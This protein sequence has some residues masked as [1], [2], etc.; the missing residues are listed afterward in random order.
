MERAAVCGSENLRNIFT[1]QH[2][3]CHWKPY[4]SQA[5]Q[6]KDIDLLIVEEKPKRGDLDGFTDGYRFI[7][8][9]RVDAGCELPIILV[10]STLQGGTSPQKDLI[11]QD[12]FV[13]TMA[14]E[15]LIKHSSPKDFKKYFPPRIPKEESDK[16]FTDLRLTLYQNEGYI[17]ELRHQIL[18]LLEKLERWDGPDGWEKVDQLLSK[19]K[20]VLQEWHL[21][22]HLPELDIS[23]AGHFRDL[24][25]KA[26]RPIIKDW[27]DQLHALV[28]RKP[29]TA[30]IPGQ[31]S[32][33]VLYIS[34]EH[35]HQ[36]MLKEQLGTLST[37]LLLE[38]IFAEDLKSAQQEAR[39]LPGNH[40]VT[41][42]A[43]FRFRDK[44]TGKRGRRNGIMIIDQLRRD[45]PDWQYLLLSNFPV[46]SYKPLMP[47]YPLQIFSK[48]DVLKNAST[49]L[50]EL[51]AAITAYN[52]TKR[53][54]LADK[55]PVALSSK[56]DEIW[57]K[58]YKDFINL[59]DFNER[60]MHLSEQ[61]TK[62]IAEMRQ[63]KSV[64]KAW[65]W[66]L[67]RPLGRTIKELEDR[68]K[69]KDITAKKLSFL[70]ERLLFRRVC[71]G[72]LAASQ[73]E[74]AKSTEHLTTKQV[75]EQIAQLTCTPGG[76]DVT[77]KNLFPNS[78]ILPSKAYEKD[79]PFITLH[80]SR[81][82]ARFI[83]KNL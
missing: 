45:Y 14:G 20:R 19:T 67:R 42:I 40:P 26:L 55:W 5:S 34:D 71:I 63:H 72:Y 76:G 15:N 62:L 73:K 75:Y 1:R 37:D 57:R 47:S 9:L 59:S 39:A 83:E 33:Y 32:A 77:D 66:S 44:Q 35:A 27:Y 13:Y 24:R 78:R 21:S 82:L 17:D 64:R 49:H 25:P 10:Q 54:Q 12:P 23:F 31:P 7:Q 53:A 65:R 68:S 29:G 41:V 48:D 51:A 69:G 60:E 80:E 52:N 18:G 70:K 22:H 79:S 50:R 28:R 74:R 43:D 38:F 56:E 36:E 81:W 8:D 46:R 16:W 2:G 6:L 61:A 4:F 11:A 30:V 58:L 3:F